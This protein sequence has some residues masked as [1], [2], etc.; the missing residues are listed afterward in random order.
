MKLKLKFKQTEIG[1]IPEEWEETIFSEAVKV[2]PKRELKKGQIAKSE[3]GF[4][5]C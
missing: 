4:G 2:N 3:V 5:S 1:I